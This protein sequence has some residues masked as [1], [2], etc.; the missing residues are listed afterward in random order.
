MPSPLLLRTEASETANTSFCI[1][2]MTQPYLLATLRQPPVSPHDLTISLSR[3]RRLRSICR[4]PSAHNLDHAL[5]P[6]PLSSCQCR[7]S[8]EDDIE[9]QSR[10][11]VLWRRGWLRANQFG[12]CVKRAARGVNQ[13]PPPWLGARSKT[14]ATTL[15]RR[16]RRVRLTTGWDP[17]REVQEAAHH[18][19]SRTGELHRR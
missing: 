12:G 8:R 4:H 3:N 17:V 18:V 2:H 16:W 5:S 19:E 9:L 6:S 1:L 11:R 13:N 7:C 15:W 14:S 10:R